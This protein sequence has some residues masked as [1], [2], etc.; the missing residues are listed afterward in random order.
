MV[1][2]ITAWLCSMYS[3]RLILQWKAMIMKQL[4]G[5]CM[6]HKQLEKDP[7]Y[8]QLRVNKLNQILHQA[9]ELSAENIL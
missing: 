9:G 3:M 4:K 1:T 6:Y 8:Q 5:E 7:N 2:I